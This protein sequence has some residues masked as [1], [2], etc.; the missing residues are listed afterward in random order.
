MKFT[1]MRRLDFYVGFFPCHI[2]AFYH[3]IRGRNK[4]ASLPE[5]LKKILVVKFLG[6]GS[7]IMTTPL[8]AELKKNYPE[9]KIHFL[10][11]SDNVPICESISLIDKVFYLEK[12]SLSRFA[13][14]LIKTLY[15]LRRQ[16]YDL[17]FNLEF[18]SNFSLLVSSLSKSKMAL[19]FGGRHEF[20]KVLCQR[21]ISY[22]N[23]A[24]IIDKFC[25][26]LKFLDIDL[27]TDTKQL[28]GL[29]EDSEA[30]ESILDLLGKRKV[31]VNK[32]F[33]VVVNVN[34]GEMSSIRKWPLEYY[35][36]VISFL[37]SK[38]KIKIMLIGGKEDVSYVS[39]LERMFPSEGDKVINIA[40]QISLKELISLMK[41]SHLYLGNDSGPLHVAEAC[42]LPSV[43]FFGP[44][45]PKVYSHSDK[46]NYNFY[47]NL[48]CSPCINVYTNKDTRCRDNVCLE[49]IKPDEVIE[50][51]QEK[52]FSSLLRG[53]I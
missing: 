52:Y 43:S 1:L 53:P 25:N 8:M 17:L 37:L 6:F 46:K 41:V 45:S 44:E 12:K 14:S 29:E 13:L 50:V 16:N 40:G 19:C 33:L 47:S 34:A 3:K 48:P 22:E 51:L 42:G 27:S 38:E 18:F 21:I 28:V 24:H 35:Q 26:F 49:L 5:D 32:D 9:A 36:R 2:L 7:I 23:E 31:D 39:S 10:T 30:R 20:R 4:K 15:Q 11:F